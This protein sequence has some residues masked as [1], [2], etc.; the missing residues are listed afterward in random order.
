[1]NRIS[2]FTPTHNSKWLNDLYNS[3]K[4]QDFYEWIIIYNNGAVPIKFDDNRV[5]EFILPVAVEWV[6]PL[7]AYGCEQATGDILFEIDHDDVLTPD[8]IFE[9]QKAFEDESV[10]F[11]YS[12][13]IHCDESFNKVQRFDERYGWSY[14]EVD[15]NNNTWGNLE[16][17]GNYFHVLD[18]HLHFEPTPNCISRIWFAP[19]HLR[20]FR[21]SVYD[22]IGGYNKGMRILDDLDL[23]CRMYQV[24]KFHHIDKGLYV[25]RI[26]G[27]N[28]WLKYN[29]EIQDNVYRIH[30]QYIESLAE[31][32]A[33]DNNL[34]LVELGGRMNAKQNYITVDLKDADLCT[35]LNNT[36]PFEDNSVGVIRAYDIFEHLNNP[37][38]IMKELYRVLAPGGYAFIQVPSTDGRGAFQD[39]THKSFWN[40]NSFLYYTDKKY[41]KYLTDCNVRFQSMRLYTTDKNNI[42]VCWVI[43]HLVK[44]GNDRVPGEVLI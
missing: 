36:W 37:I 19:N 22:Q 17:K 42:D 43:A 33:K 15:F 41:N 40:Q 14:R 26:H 20:A 39:P 18:E 44:L 4:D 7:K 28:S 32:W 23:M 35:D 10:G 11:V 21:K 8:A 24:T 13:T 2:I 25:Y 3:I 38:H 5:K 30:D 34:N 27:E 29:K 31:K 6:G 1:M 9:V 16:I 12:N